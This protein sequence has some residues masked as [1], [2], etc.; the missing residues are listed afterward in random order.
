MSHCLCPSLPTHQPA[1]APSNAGLLAFP[2]LGLPPQHCPG[3]HAWET[4][5]SHCSASVP[6][7]CGA[8]AAQSAALLSMWRCHR[9]WVRPREAEGEAVVRYLGTVGRDGYLELCVSAASGQFQ[10][11]SSCLGDVFVP[12]GSHVINHVSSGSWRQ[13]V[14]PLRALLG[15][16]FLCL[17]VHPENEDWTC[18]EQSASLDIKSFFGFE[19]T[20]EKIA[21][22]H[23]TSNIKKVSVCLGM[24][25]KG[26]VG[27]SERTAAARAFFSLLFT[28]GGK[29]STF[30][31]THNPPASSL[32]SI[33]VTSMNHCTQ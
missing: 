17:Q 27:V 22:K 30:T 14:S 29:I 1:P 28:C 21:M 18:F 2:P 12:H 5:L 9:C 13:V 23:Y 10:P 31:Q 11:Q 32:P 4:R 6:G 19:S 26:E 15:T 20:V 33:R 25:W 3:S 24:L 7:A 8:R 16:G